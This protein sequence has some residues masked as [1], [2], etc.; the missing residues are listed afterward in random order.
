MLVHRGVNLQLIGMDAYG[1]TLVADW[2]QLYDASTHSIGQRGR[3][4][5]A[6]TS[7]RKTPRE[8]GI[9]RPN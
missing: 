6:L 4:C 9:K 8:R 5:I 3:T 1:P 7:A 2:S